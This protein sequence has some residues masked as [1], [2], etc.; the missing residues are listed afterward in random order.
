MRDS[1]SR[2]HTRKWWEK[3]DVYLM[4]KWCQSMSDGMSY[5]ALSSSESFLPVILSGT[6]PF[7]CKQNGISLN[8][9]NM[10]PIV[11]RSNNWYLRLYLPAKSSSLLKSLNSHHE[12]NHSNLW[13]FKSI[14]FCNSVFNVNSLYV[15]SNLWTFKSII[16]CNRVFK[17][18]SLDV[19]KPFSRISLFTIGIFRLRSLKSEHN[20]P[21]TG[22]ACIG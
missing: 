10:L 7:K 19:N 12:I 21:Y 3:Q 18:K 20:A 4:F 22:A 16:F 14:I 5:D 8:C 6:V 11:S 15:T 2:L 13:I 17:L 9:R 1:S